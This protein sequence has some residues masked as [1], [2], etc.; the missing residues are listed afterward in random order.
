MLVVVFKGKRSRKTILY[1]NNL[2]TFLRFLY[3]INYQLIFLFLGCLSEWMLVK[4]LG[5]QDLYPWYQQAFVLWIIF[6]WVEKDKKNVMLF[7][8]FQFLNPSTKDFFSGQGE[9]CFGSFISS[10]KTYFLKSGTRILLLDVMKIICPPTSLVC[11]S[12]LH[13]DLK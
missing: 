4:Q 11:F 13:K 6:L 8:A 9:W 5:Y 10:C 3:F 1:L 7:T 2:T 12:Y